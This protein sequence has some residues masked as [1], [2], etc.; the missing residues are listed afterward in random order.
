MLGGL[1]LKLA[2]IKSVPLEKSLRE[3]GFRRRL[4]QP[5]WLLVV[6][7]SLS[8]SL[9]FREC[10]VGRWSYSV[11]AEPSRGKISGEGWAG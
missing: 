1:T 3:A 4:R 11:G 10:Y 8:A 7:G 6:A 2:P 5:L 9:V